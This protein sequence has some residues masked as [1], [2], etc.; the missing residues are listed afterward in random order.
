[1][2]KILVLCLGFTIIACK[3]EPK[4]YATLSGKIENPDESKIIRVFQGRNYEKNITVNDDGTFND[5]LKVV[6]GHYSFQ[7]GKEYGQ[8]YLKNNNHTTFETDNNAFVD[9]MEF[10]GDASDIN[11]FSVQSF[12]ISKQYFTEDLISSGTKEDV[13]KAIENYKSD[14][15]G[16]K[17]KYADVDSVQVAVM[18][19]NV[20]GTI[21]QLSRFMSS[22][23]ATRDEFPKGSPSPAFENYENFAGGEMSLSDF[24]GKYVYFDI[25]ATW[26][27]PCIREIPSLKKIE[28]QYKD[29]NIQF[30]SIS[31]DEGRGYKGNKVAAYE[32]WKKMVADK[33]LGGTQLI[34]DDGFKSTFIRDYKINGIPRFILVDPE[35]N[36]VN[37]DAPRPSSTVLIE[38]FDELGI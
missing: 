27:G 29:K 14:Y 13:E 2:R 20:E 24:K 28:E 7:H 25:W 9:S 21:Q 36:I 22:K 8:I 5:T 26:C 16:L 38:L 4:D 18:D 31:I 23:L 12:L 15:E 6:A 10:K 35:G 37:A 32:A 34:A 30:V 19:K 17:N 3:S 33:D 11:N 1:M